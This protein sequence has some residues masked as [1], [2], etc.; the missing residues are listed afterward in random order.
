MAQEVRIVESK[1]T[2]WGAAENRSRL[3]VQA[4][5]K[6]G[7]PELAKHA[8]ALLVAARKGYTA[9]YKEVSGNA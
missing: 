6:L 4:F 3:L 9:T 1:L 8:H 5:I 2:N 7:E